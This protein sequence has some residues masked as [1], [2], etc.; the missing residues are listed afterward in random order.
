MLFTCLCIYL[1]SS[2]LKSTHMCYR[3]TTN[4]R[5]ASPHTTNLV[6]P[7]LSQSDQQRKALTVGSLCRLERCESKRGRNILRHTAKW[8]FDHV[9]KKAGVYHHPRLEYLTNKN[10][11][12]ET[13]GSVLNQPKIVILNISHSVYCARMC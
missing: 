7:L 5:M 4:K 2:F 9:V 1:R 8:G 3:I 11:K 13:H 10:Q 12:I 6:G